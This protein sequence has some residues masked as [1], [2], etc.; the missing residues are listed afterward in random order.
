MSASFE[1]PSVAQ[2]AETT[3]NEPVWR[4]FRYVWLIFL[5]VFLV[6]LLRR[7]WI[8]DDAYITFRTVD[9][10]INGYRLVWNI[11]ERVQAYTHPLWMVMVSAAY[12]VTREMYLT[13]LIL[14][15][16]I[17]L[18]A[19]AALARWLSISEAAAAV[20]VFALTMSKAF[21]DFS[22]AGLE[23]PLSHLLLAIFFLVLFRKP[24]T[25][26]T[27]FWLS[28]IA[29]LAAVNRMDTILLYIP[30][31][32]YALWVTRS[33]R[34]FWGMVLGQLPFILWEIFSLVYYGFPFP[35]TA[36]A[37]L[38]TGIPSGEYI[39]Q[40]LLYLLNSLEHD[41]ITLLLILAGV[42][43]GLIS[44][45]G[46]SIMG[47]LG[48]LL[49]MAYVVKVGGDFMSGRFLTVPLFGAA[50][51]LAR[52][53]FGRLGVAAQMAVFGVI[54]AIGMSVANPTL[55]I[56]D[57]GRLDQGP[58]HIGENG[59]LDERMLYYGGTGLMNARR[60][61]DLP[62]FY[63]GE[64]GEAARNSGRVVADNYGIG[65][66]GFYAGPDVY[67][68]DK[69]A[70]ADPL[71]ARLPAPRKVDWRIGHLERTLPAGYFDSLHLK[72]NVLHDE[73]LHEY[74]DQLILIT[75]GGLFDPKR[76]LAIWKMNTGQFDE[77]IDTD[78]YLYPDRQTVVASDWQTPLDNGTACSSPDALPMTD[79]GV[80]VIMPDV[81]KTGELQ[82]GLDHNDEYSVTYFLGEKEISRQWVRTAFLPEPGGISARWVKTPARAIHSGFDT[83]VILPEDGD[84]DYCFGYLIEAGNE[85]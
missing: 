2:R 21:M 43:G 1:I 14:Q 56:S 59:I 64:Y 25:S 70:L 68:L 79:S 23:N 45:Q 17:S 13:V 69:L 52:L 12:F 26:R 4:P 60:T 20:G 57:Y 40:G 71:L 72:R 55:H 54:L 42:T 24:L 34:S 46:R 50:I 74:Y 51:L 7:A 83:I 10:F 36:Y 5:G 48:V 78:A 32:G 30:A 82:I 84:G 47:A 19:V 16:G 33:R 15:V 38:N 75:R 53:D 3:I 81:T 8:C 29:S 35:N 77:L 37:K 41:P 28:L 73:N 65:F 58:V 67:V 49:Y 11:G 61:L 63:W 31:L 39:Q 6:V 66:Y 85:E 62:N 18:A 44:R 76:W 27:A 80:V 22:T 9:N